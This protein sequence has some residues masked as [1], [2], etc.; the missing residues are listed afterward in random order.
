[1]EILLLNVAS[2]ALET[3]V[4]RVSVDKDLQ[5]GRRTSVQGLVEKEEK[6]TYIS[7]DDSHGDS[8][9]ENVEKGRLSGTRD[10]HQSGERSRLDPSVDVVEQSARS[11]LNRDIVAEV[12]KVED[13]RLLLDRDVLGVLDIVLA[14]PCG[15]AGSSLDVVL[16]GLLALVRLGNSGSRVQLELSLGLGT[17]DEL[18][19]GE[20]ESAESDEEDDDNSVV[21]ETKKQSRTSAAAGGFDIHIRPV[22]TSI[23]ASGSTSR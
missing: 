2:L 4:S 6:R 13:G 5:S 21:S 12:L 1:V 18:G 16:S 17:G 15:G 22:L 19:G 8:R 7:S 14:L 9:G 11:S 23:C 10:T 20:V 3:V